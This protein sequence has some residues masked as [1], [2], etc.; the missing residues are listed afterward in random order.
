MYA[1]EGYG[2]ASNIKRPNQRALGWRRTSYLRNVSQGNPIFRSNPPWPCFGAIMSGMS[3]QE[4][5]SLALPRIQF[6]F[7]ALL[8]AAPDAMLIADNQGR[9]VFVNCQTK[10]L[11]GYSDS[12]L[13]G[14]TLEV[15]VPPRFR[16][17]HATHRAGYFAQSPH[18]RPITAGLDLYGIRKDGTEFPAEISLNP[19]Q[20]P[21][22]TMVISA[23]RDIT[24]R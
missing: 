22:G 10:Q 5:P 6:N 19:I 7:R 17:K 15:L 11:F 18:I 20:T 1:S 23:I 8:D 4:F 21:D 3:G 24:D 14:Q 2:W 13:L 9:I 16:A 12:E